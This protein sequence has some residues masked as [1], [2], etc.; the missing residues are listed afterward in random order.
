MPEQEKRLRREG[1]WGGK[2]KGSGT[3]NKW[4]EKLIHTNIR[5]PE[6]L[7]LKLERRAL[8]NQNSLSC[9][10]VELLKGIEKWI[11]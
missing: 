7:Y 11:K 8:N 9:T 1:G 4:N 6:S 10:V 2:R 5:I 3:K